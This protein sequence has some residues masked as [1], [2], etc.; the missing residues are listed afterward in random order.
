MLWEDPLLAASEMSLPAESRGFGGQPGGPK[1]QQRRASPIPDLKLPRRQP[2]Q[3]A[4]NSLP[5]QFPVPS[6]GVEL[7]PFV[8]FCHSS[9]TECP[10]WGHLLCAVCEQDSLEARSLMEKVDKEQC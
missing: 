8:G 4:P 9:F 7:T 3:R 2:V 6:S 1:G 5:F 10:L